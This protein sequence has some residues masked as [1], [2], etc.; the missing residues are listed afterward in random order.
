MSTKFGVILAALGGVRSSPPLY[1]PPDPQGRACPPPQP[2]WVRGEPAAGGTG[3]GV[4]APTRALRGAFPLRR[5]RR[6]PVAS[7]PPPNTPK[8]GCLL[9]P[10]THPPWHPV[11]EPPLRFFGTRAG[12]R[13]PRGPQKGGWLRPPRGGLSAG[14]LEK[15]RGGRPGGR[16]RQPGPRLFTC[17]GR[18]W[19]RPRPGGLVHEA[20]WPAAARAATKKPRSEL[21]VCSL[22]APARRGLTPDLSWRDREQK[23]APRAR[24]RILPRRFAAGKPE[25]GAFSGG[26]R[27]K[28]GAPRGPQAFQTNPPSPP[29]HHHRHPQVSPYTLALLLV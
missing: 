18:N 20:T 2:G 5:A 19:P 1:Q 11:S 12:H 8:R 14:G 6:V 10:S 15:P 24:A 29:H 4:L 17:R 28:L 25:R 3:E 23:R 7:V 22:R 13:G 16:W 26:R 9:D 21:I 27:T